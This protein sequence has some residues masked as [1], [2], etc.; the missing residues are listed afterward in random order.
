[1]VS[2]EQWV[3][4]TL[5]GSEEQSRRRWWEMTGQ[6]QWEEEEG[7]AKAVSSSET[8]GKIFV[9]VKTYFVSKGNQHFK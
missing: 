9:S 7:L 2:A 3:L 5:E 1:M 6:V 4:Q 8:F